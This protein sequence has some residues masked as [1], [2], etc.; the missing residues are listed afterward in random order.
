MVIWNLMFGIHLFAFTITR[1]IYF[2]KRSSV[3]I[4]RYSLVTC[5]PQIYFGKY[6]HASI[7]YRRN[8]YFYT[9]SKLKANCSDKLFVLLV[10]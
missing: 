4:V 7:S 8:Q 10:K 3:D 9:L 5:K 6:W 1:C 2:I